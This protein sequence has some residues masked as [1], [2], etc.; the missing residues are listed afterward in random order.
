MPL[1]I[2]VK[3]LVRDLPAL[4]ERLLK[5]GGVCK[6]PRLFERNVRYDTPDQALLG[7]GEL[8]RLRQDD[9]ALVTFKAEPP[10]LQALSGE[11]RI[12][13]EIEFAVSDAESA[14]TVFR[15]LGYHPAQTYEK[16][17]E[18]FTIGPVELVLDE[19]PF[20]DF[21]ELE[22]AEAD[23]KPVAT[24]LGLAWEQRLL[25]N[26]LG[27]LHFFNQIYRLNLNDLTFEAFA[28]VAHR[29]TPFIKE[30]DIP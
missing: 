5:A 20:G 22:G 21:V 6:R 7:R 25:G 4:R 17:R 14:D 19:L 29:L 27:L 13:E 15:R 2:E 12:R 30:A 11:A 3:F 16:Y 10:E 1:E 23:L 18:T 9:R 28:G 26:Y 8:L 24:Q